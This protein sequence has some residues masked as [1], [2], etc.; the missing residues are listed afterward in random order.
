MLSNT[1]LPT[2]FDSNKFQNVQAFVDYAYSIFM[3]NFHFQNST[4]LFQGKPVVA[5]PKILNCDN[6][7]NHCN[8]K[9]FSCSNCP[10]INKEDIFHHVCSDE[11]PNLTVLPEF[12]YKNNR[13]PGIFNR[14]RASKLAWL[15]FMI[16]NFNNTQY[17]RYYNM[18]ASN[19]EVNHFFWLYHEQY[20]LIL[21]EEKGGNRLYIRTCYDIKSDRDEKK[22]YAQYKKYLRQI[23]R[24]ARST[25]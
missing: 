23:E 3:N 2:L 1:H 11:D 17:I 15:K 22:H 14:I 13:T 5:R 10:F 4:I 7:G 19:R 16:E 6:C 24:S 20:I 18:P 12:K 25:S 21:V 9:L 8:N